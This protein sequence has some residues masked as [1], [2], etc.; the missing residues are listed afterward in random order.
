MPSVITFLIN[1][2]EYIP[3]GQLGPLVACYWFKISLIAASLIFFLFFALYIVVK[4]FK[5]FKMIYNYNKKNVQIEKLDL[6]NNKI[7]IDKNMKKLADIK[8]N[9]T[10]IKNKTNKE[11]LTTEFQ[12]ERKFANTTFKTTSVYIGMFKKSSHKCL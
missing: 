2:T 12:N 10:E 7:E 5:I 11:N 6:D 4:C 9:L 1:I 8:Q 3:V